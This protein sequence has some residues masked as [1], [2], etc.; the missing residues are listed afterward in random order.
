M[1][2]AREPWLSR[3]SR[4]KR[5]ARAEAAAEGRRRGG[6][7]PKAAGTETDAPPAAVPPESSAPPPARTMEHKEVAVED[8]PP[9]E[10]LGRDSDYTV[11]LKE[12]VPEALTRAAL[13]K[14]WRSD[15]VFAN[16]DGLNLYDKDY[17]LAATELVS[18]DEM[19]RIWEGTAPADEPRARPADDETADGALPEEA[20]TIESR[21]GAAEAPEAG[22]DER[23]APGTAPRGKT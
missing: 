20:V 1:T 22:G 7:L 6:A 21:E 8:L 18:P 11:F 3:W 5:E 9:I 4:L 23:P 15:P 13:Q 14:L 2:D 19:R 10:S 17:S 16:L 12:G